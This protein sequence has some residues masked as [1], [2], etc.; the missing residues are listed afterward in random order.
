[1]TTA[2]MAAAGGGG[3][4]GRGRGRGFGAGPAP[5]VELKAW[6]DKL[7]NFAAADG[8]I[9]ADVVP[10]TA[11]TLVPAARGRR[12]GGGGGGGAPPAAPVLKDVKASVKFSLADGNIAKY[13][14]HVTGTRT[15][16]DGTDTPIDNTTSTEIK[17]IGATK[18]EVPA[19]A[20]AK[21]DAPPAP[22]AQ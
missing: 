17:D 4:G 22:A 3:G 8:A 12:G 5:A 6:E 10:E 7:S 20:K 18:F 16:A 2:E 13:E 1:M 11:K 21:L 19:E 14:M 9:T 15:A